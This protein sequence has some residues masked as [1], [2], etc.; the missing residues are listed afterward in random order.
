MQQLVSD[1][2]F[3]WE[4]YILRKFLKPIA[5][6]ALVRTAADEIRIT[7]FSKSFG[8]KEINSLVATSNKLTQ[9]FV[10]L[11]TSGLRPD[12]ARG[13]PAGLRCVVNFGNKGPF[14]Y[15]VRLATLAFAC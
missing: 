14:L 11:V 3:T 6:V 7:I 13:P 4:I 15:Q 10:G 9:N 5:R 8:A 12:L 1:T 2:I